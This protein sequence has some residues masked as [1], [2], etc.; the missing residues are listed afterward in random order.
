MH[1][2]DAPHARVQFRVRDALV[3]WIT[4][5]A[6]VALALAFAPFNVWPLAVVCPA[7]LFIC[8]HGVAPGRAAWRGFLFTSGTFLA[9]TYWL[10]HSIHVIG[11]APLWV[12]LLLMLG[13]V[14]IMGAYT[15][16][17]GYVQARWLPPRG[18]IRHLL[19]LPAAWLLVEWFRG[20]FLSGFPWLSLGYSQIDAPIA[21]LAPIGGVYGV[22]LGTVFAAGALAQFALAQRLRERVICV[23]LVALPYLAGWPLL[24]TEWTRPEGRPISVAIVQGAVP[25]EMKWSKEY[26]DR[27]LELY[28]SLT[29]PELGRD[30]ILWPEAALPALAHE[31][32]DYL[33]SLWAEARAHHSDLVMGLLHFDAEGRTYRNGLLALSDANY[34]YDKRRLVPFGEFFP[35]PQF[36]RNWMKLMSLPY[37]DFV[38]GAPSQPPLPAGGV[39]LGA[40]ICYE[41]AYGAEQLAVLARATVLVNVTNDAW[42]GDSTARH[43]H[44][45]IS[46]MRAL[47]AGRPLLRAANDGISAMLDATGHIVASL[48]QPRPGVL[49]GTVQPRTGLTPYARVGNVPVVALSVLVLLGGSVAAWRMRRVR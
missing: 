42:F 1:V 21:G 34:W 40:T 3:T 5:P 16:L 48:P 44:L 11:E 4:L 49:T 25:Q 9:G 12:A 14:A 17:L 28:R 37:T 19:L 33:A 29:R 2:P 22:G 6:G 27:T 15:A 46:R 45:E 38:P 7:L 47:E 23:A 10:Y 32:N 26:R 24:G 18:R 43:Q 30:L 13:L 39:L 8:W 31:L 41:D 20:W 35:V 36:V